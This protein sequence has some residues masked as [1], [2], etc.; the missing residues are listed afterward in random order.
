MTG[1]SSHALRRARRPPRR[2]RSLNRPKAANA[3][4]Y[5][6]GDP[7]EDHADTFTASGATFTPPEHFD[8]CVLGAVVKNGRQYQKTHEWRYVTARRWW[9]PNI[10]PGD[11]RSIVDAPWQPVQDEGGVGAG[12]ADVAAERTSEVIMFATG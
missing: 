5:R 4:Q 11:A 3:G 12:G 9:L 7:A 10:E 2:K 1:F 8:G 6:H